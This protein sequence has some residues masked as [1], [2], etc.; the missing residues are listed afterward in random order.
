[1]VDERIKVLARN[2]INYSCRLQPG[3]KVLIETIHLELPLVTELIKEA[4][5]VGAIPFVTIKNRTV[6][7]A[8]LMGATEEQMKMMAKYEAA[9]MSDMDAYIGIRSG[10]NTSELSDVPSDKLGIYNKYFWHE[11]HGKIRVPKTKWVVLRYPSPSMA[12]L[13]NMS[14][15]AFEDFY[16]NVCNLDYS[17]MSKAMDALVE[18]M[19]RT[20]KVRI[21]GPETDL[22]F[23]IKGIPV[24]KC[25]GKMNI[26]DG[27]V[28]TAPVKDSVNG[29]IT[30]NAPSE[31]QGFTYENIRLE[32]KDGK[33]V[34]ATANNTERINKV[35]DTDEGARYV[36]EFAIGVNPYITKP[37]KDILFDEK[38]AGSIHFTPGSSYDDAFNGNKSAI[39]WDLV[40]IQTPEYGGGEIYFDDVLVRKDGRFVLP[41]LEALNPENLK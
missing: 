33:I 6:D 12:Q 3:E 21:V 41:E 18:L 9:R 36:G 8:L 20:D 16:F 2:L 35:F 4:Y 25:D 31:Y 15:E 5:R 39:H 23:S 40:Y 26:P 10:N 22:T 34:K 28:Y 11:V 14:T 32:F 13:A 30:Y 17:K 1:M 24:V 27:E 19:E 37:M 38:I 29:Y 7:R